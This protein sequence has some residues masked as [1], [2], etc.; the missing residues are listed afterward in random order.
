MNITNDR[1]LIVDSSPG[2]AGTFFSWKNANGEVMITDTVGGIFPGYYLFRLKDTMGFPLEFAV[3]KLLTAGYTIDW[4]SYIEEA[5]KQKRWDYQTY[6]EL[7]YL[8]RELREYRD[9]LHEVIQRFKVYVMKNP[10]P[11]M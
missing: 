2:G 6:D 4:V 9:Y 8:Q 10:H 7:M 3:D 5:R 11:E 1:V